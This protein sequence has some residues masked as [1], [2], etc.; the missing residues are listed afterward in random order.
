M[1][2]TLIDTGSC[3][4][5]FDRDDMERI[6]ELTEKYQDRPINFADAALLAIAEH[7]QLNSIISIAS[8]F[9]IYRTSLD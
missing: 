8:D 4:A 6:I 3:I 7:K 2:Q 1:E 9:Q 5:L